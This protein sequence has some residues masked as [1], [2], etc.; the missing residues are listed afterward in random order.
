MP[1]CSSNARP[2]RSFPGQTL[3]PVKSNVRASGASGVS[4]RLAR[5]GP[6]DLARARRT[7]ARKSVWR[8]TQRRAASSCG[9]AQ[10]VRAARS[11]LSCWGPAMPRSGASERREGVA[12]ATAG[13]VAERSSPGGRGCQRSIEARWPPA[14]LGPPAWRAVRRKR[15][16]FP[17]AP[18][19]RLLTSPRATQASPRPRYPPRSS[20]VRASGKPRRWDRP[21]GAPSAGSAHATP[22]LLPI[23]C[24]RAPS[25]A[26]IATSTLPPSLLPIVESQWKAARCDLLTSSEQRRRGQAHTRDPAG[27]ARQ[28]GWLGTS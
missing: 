11:R 16:R 23:G 3:P 26:G 18:P 6:H 19:H 9:C 1:R 27:E 14:P 28:R 25:N 20:P 5:G 15:P 10:R 4:E 7:P 24:S 8:P 22:S 2:E 17:L 12:W 13:G 21:P